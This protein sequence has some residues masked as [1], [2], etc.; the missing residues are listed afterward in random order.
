MRCY[1]RQ[2][3][4]VVAS[5]LENRALLPDDSDAWLGW[6]REHESSFRTRD[7]GPYDDYDGF[8]QRPEFGRRGFG[9]E[10][11]YRRPFVSTS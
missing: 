10:F 3:Q 5:R 11:C 1:R 8:P 2:H 4:S 7:L 6:R 9:L